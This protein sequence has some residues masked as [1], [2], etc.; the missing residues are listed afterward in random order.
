MGVVPTTDLLIERDTELQAVDDALR[1]A[2]AGIGNVVLI[3]GEAGVGKTSVVRAAQRIAARIGARILS[4]ACDDL[5][6]SR[7]LGPIRDLAGASAGPLRAALSRSDREELL[8]GLRHE[9][10]VRPHPTLLAIEDAHWADDATI[11]I[12]TW[13]ARRIAELPAVLLLTYRPEELGTAHPLRRVLG[14]LGGV[15]VRRLP[16]DP[17]SEDGVAA[18]VVAAG[19]AVRT[20]QTTAQID[21]G[22]LFRQTGGNAFFVTEVLAN[23]VAVVPPTIAEAVLARVRLLTAPTQDALRQLAVLPGGARHEDADALL[24]DAVAVLSEAE[25]VGVLVVGDNRVSF[26]HELARRALLESMPTPLARQLHQRALDAQLQRSRPDLSLVLHHG[27]AVG[28]RDVLIRFGPRAAREAA[29]AGAHGEAVEHFRR[30]LRAEDAFGTEERAELLEGYAIECFAIGSAPDGVDAQERAVA[31]RT[32]LGDPVRL[33]SALRWL[34]RLRWYSGRDGAADEAA[35]EAVQILE[36]AGDLTQLAWAHSNAAQLAVLASRD[37]E[38]G[39]L[40]PLAVEWARRSG[41]AAVLAHALNNAGVQRWRAGD[42]A[43]GAALLAESLRIAVDLGQSDDASRAYVNW[44]G[45][46]LDGID[47]PAAEQ[48]LT[49]AIAFADRTGQLSYFRFLR[50]QLAVVLQDTGRLQEALAVA[51]EALDA[52]TDVSTALFLAVV[53]KVRVRTGDDDAQEVL[54][55]LAADVRG[56]DSLQRLL[57]LAGAL[58]E[59]AWLRDRPDEIITGV[60]R[61]YAVAID[62]GHSWALSELGYWRWKAGADDPAPDGDN[63][64]VLQMTGRPREAAA[65]WLRVNRPYEQARA[66]LEAA[67][68]DDLAAALTIADSLGAVPLARRIRAG[69]GSPRWH[70]SPRGSGETARRNPFSLTGRQL[71]ILALLTSGMTNAEIAERLVLSVRTVDNHVA[72]VLEKLQV[73]TR[74]AAAAKAIDLGLTG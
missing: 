7:T 24:T 45:G 50:T 1:E 51:Q 12:L 42:A 18:L 40:A 30:V 15:R 10:T 34:S 5:L 39:E 21:P 69:S 37:R 70:A 6:T 9:L 27:S 43:N 29:A 58:A 35:R 33:G 13:L 11:D 62:R 71:E 46:H 36:G 2:A 32:T 16:L 60:D 63:P 65:E 64:F 41:D 74:K 25:R 55:A 66:L 53:A 49:E 73:P 47:Y 22:E 52:P 67:G 26:R 20:A 48:L 31:L 61:A 56:A 8:D 28:N 72:A 38:A 23:P 68:P 14:R 19:P 57:P 44:I 59:Q 17:L 4:A 54:D 3:T